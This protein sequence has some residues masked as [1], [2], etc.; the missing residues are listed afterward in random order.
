MEQITLKLEPASKT[1]LY[2]QL[3]HYIVTEIGKGQIVAGEKL[4]SKKGLAAHL[5]VSQTT[6][7]TAYGMLMAEGYVVSRPRSGYY[8]CKVERLSPSAAPEPPPLQPVLVPEPAYS[9][10]FGTSGVDM[11]SFPYAT[12]AKLTRETL[13]RHPDLLR[14]GSNQ[15]DAVLRETLAKYLHEYRAVNCDAR[16][17]VVGAGVEYLLDM[18]C[19]L[20]D[21][22]CRIAMEN[23][24]YPKA[25]T[26]FCNNARTV[27]PIEVNHGGL[28]IDALS[29]SGA[30]C[31]Y[32]TPS[33]QFPTGIVMPIGRR[34]QLL[35]WAAQETGR[36][37]I[38]DDYDSEFRYSGKPIPALQGLDQNG[39]V[40]YLSTFSRSIAPSIRIAYMVLPPALLDR[41]EQ[42]FGHYRCTVSRFEQ[43]TLA[44]FIGGGHLSRHLNRMRTLYRRRKDSLL[45]SLAHYFPQGSYSISGEQTGLHLMLRI[46]TER[47]ETELLAAASKAGI[48][49]AALSDYLITPLPQKMS[50]SF[51]LGY[52]A[53]EPEEIESAVRLLATVWF[54]G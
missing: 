13:Y 38:E 51:V 18:L 14:I 26:I 20:L 8:A 48:R 4:P 39:R 1:P 44:R 36:Y 27:L 37:L 16:Q 12:W 24:C 45:A 2:E 29:S 10:S 34:T 33:H 41:Y 53:M 49:L 35:N 22:D 28:C 19:Q 17:I 30:A 3:Y 52:C 15:G 21:T 47:R 42:R 11:H 9:Y 31:A 7:E 54:G 46:H 25:Y 32:V 23:P 5:K 6:V 43:H 50:A 40:V